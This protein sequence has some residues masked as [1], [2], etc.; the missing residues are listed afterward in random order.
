MEIMQAEPRQ[1]HPV[2]IYALKIVHSNAGKR[3]QMAFPSMKEG[4]KWFACHV[5]NCLVACPVGAIEIVDTW[6][7]DGG[8]F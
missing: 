4:E 6:K 2:W 3:I 8:Y 7:V 1:M 5:F